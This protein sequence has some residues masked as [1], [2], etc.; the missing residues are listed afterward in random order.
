MKKQIEHRVTQAEITWNFIGLNQHEKEEF[1]SQ[2]P[3]NFTA[4]IGKY[5]SN[6]RT[7]GKRKITVGKL[8]MKQFKYYD[9]VIIK[10]VKDEL[11][12]DIYA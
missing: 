11:I 5:I 2:L 8:A 6:N 10:I 9:L 1:Y 4:R 7:I 12:I 3:N